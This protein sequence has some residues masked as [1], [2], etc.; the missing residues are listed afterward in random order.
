[1]CPTM[2][3][4]LKT[5]SP[6]INDDNQYVSRKNDKISSEEVPLLINNW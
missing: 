5:G 3:H 2:P 6:P 1:V 4:I